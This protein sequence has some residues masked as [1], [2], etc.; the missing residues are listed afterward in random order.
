MEGQFT[1]NSFPSTFVVVCVEGYFCGGHALKSNATSVFRCL[2][3]CKSLKR[4]Y[5]RRFAGKLGARELYE[6]SR[7]KLIYEPGE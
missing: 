1:L 5:A 4:K 3:F 6:K 7:D 2:E